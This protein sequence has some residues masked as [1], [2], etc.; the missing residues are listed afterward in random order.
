MLKKMIALC[1]VCMLTLAFL[2]VQAEENKGEW[3]N[4][5]LLGSDDRDMS[6]HSGRTDTII[7]FSVNRE[8][9][10][11]K[12]TSIMR[13]TWVKI[14]GRK[15]NKINA[16]NVFGGPELAMETVNTSFG[17]NI[18]DYILINFRDMVDIVD[19]FGGVDLELSQS[20]VKIANDY[21][22]SYKGEA[23]NQE[24]YEDYSLIASAGMVH[25]NGMQAMAHCRDR[26]TDSDFGRVMRGQDTLL[27]LA[28]KAQNME[29]DAC[30]DIAGEIMSFVETNLTDEEVKELGKAVLTMDV[31][32]VGQNR[33]PADGTYK[34][35]TF[36][37]VWCIRPNLEK[38][39]QILKSYIY[40]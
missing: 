35:G 6:K 28:E 17:T 20:E 25:L 21:I 7:I 22:N 36:D 37:G 5:L 33:L 10:S 27:A 18:Q 9:G 2:G 23:H 13:D 1:L 8:L 24:P 14:P 32:N 38:N 4:I 40:G 19:L 39:A 29:V 3:W 26:Y 34:S 11:A 31:E 12:M 16:A 15:K 30:L